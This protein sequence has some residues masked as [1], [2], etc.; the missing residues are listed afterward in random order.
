MPRKAPISITT[1]CA[2]SR[3]A[4]TSIST[5]YVAPWRRWAGPK[6][7]SA[8]LCAIMTW[9]E[10]PTANM[11]PSAIVEDSRRQDVFVPI[12][13]R[14]ERWCI[15]KRHRSLDERVEKRFAEEVVHHREAP[16]RI[17]ARAEAR[18]QGRDLT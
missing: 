2:L 4:R 1:R 9:S 15:R 8:K 7:G 13:P 11:T 17:P 14:V 18:R 12:E 5:A 16:R 10:T 3:G 6:N